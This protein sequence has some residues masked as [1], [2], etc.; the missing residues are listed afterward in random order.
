MYGNRKQCEHRS[1]LGALTIPENRLIQMQEHVNKVVSA[2]G[3]HAQRPGYLPFHYEA[4]LVDTHECI[5]ESYPGG[6]VVVGIPFIER[7][8]FS[9]KEEGDVTE[10]D[11]LAA[12]IAH[13]MAHVVLGHCHKQFETKMF[14]DIG[15]LLSFIGLG[16]AAIAH[17][18]NRSSSTTKKILYASLVLYLCVRMHMRSLPERLRK[19]EYEADK[20]GIELMQRAGYNLRGSLVALKRGP[21]YF[22]GENTAR[23]ATHPPIEARIK[24]NQHTIKEI[25]RRGQID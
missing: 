10:Y 25:E 12:P 22:A 8:F 3:V 20:F 15:R 19:R 24:A 9:R 5:A 6:K 16:Q 7:V 21:S 4:T 17:M 13:E 18:F 2:L 11:I 14:C 23:D 1:K